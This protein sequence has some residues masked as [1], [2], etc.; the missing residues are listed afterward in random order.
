MISIV[1]VLETLL[2]IVKRRRM[3]AAKAAIIE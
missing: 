3:P 1:A 2:K